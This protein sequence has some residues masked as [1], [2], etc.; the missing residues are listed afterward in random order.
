MPR[1]PSIKLRPSDARRWMVC[2]ASPGYIAA[3]QDKIPDTEEDYTVE[4]QNAHELAQAMLTDD[5]LTI[6]QYASD[7]EMMEHVSGYAFFCRQA[8]N[9]NPH[10]MLVETA[11]PVFYMKGKDGYVDC[12]VIET[13]RDR[14]H[15]IDLKYGRGKKVHAKN[16]PQLSIYALGL[17]DELADLY[18]F[19]DATE[20]WITIY[21]PRIPD[22][23]DQVSNT[24]YTNIGELRLFGQEIGS[25]AAGIKANPDK[26]PFAPG[27]VTCDFCPAESFCTKRALWLLGTIEELSSGE[28]ASNG[29]LALLDDTRPTAITALPAPEALTPEQTARILSVA[30]TISKWLNKL[31]EHAALS[32]IQLGTKYP[33]YKIVESRRNRR[34]LNEDEAAKALRRCMPRKLIYQENLITPTKALEYLKARKTRKTI[35]EAVEAQIVR[36]VGEATLVPVS[37][38][39]PELV[40]IKAEDEFYDEDDGTS[41]L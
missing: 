5:E 33:G 38:N 32:A 20:V 25:I 8:A 24:W 27:D 39:R 16:N 26:Q 15:I 29:A 41:L 36:P 28:D 6:E 1:T 19:T 2:R 23:H 22:E 40:D 30:P 31:E 37:D 4:G 7:K 10:T 14:L 18:P 35:R 11:V 34:W 12:A 21:Q 13:K 3:N 9:G 17:I